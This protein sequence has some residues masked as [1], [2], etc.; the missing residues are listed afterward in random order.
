MTCYYKENCKL[1]LYVHKVLRKV[2]RPNKDEVG[3][4]CRRLCPRNSVIRAG[5][6]VAL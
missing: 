6:V 5:H 4:Q 1:L 2:Y 3:G